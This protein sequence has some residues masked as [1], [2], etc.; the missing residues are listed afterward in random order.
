M[1]DS[2]GTYQATLANAVGCDSVV[3]LEP[4]I[5]RSYTTDSMV[6]CDSA[7][8]NGNMYY[9]S[10]FYVDTLQTAEGCDSII[11]MDLTINNAVSTDDSI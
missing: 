5:I 3:T 8:W 1:Y 10:G 9:T 2:S 7:M 11:T 4:L 6:A